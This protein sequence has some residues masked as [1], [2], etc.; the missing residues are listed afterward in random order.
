MPT[1]FSMVSVSVCVLG[2]IG[3]NYARYVCYGVG[4]CVH[5]SC[6]IGLGNI[7]CNYAHYV[8]DGVGQCVYM[9]IPG[10]NYAHYVYYGVGQCVYASCIAQ[11]K[12]KWFSFP[13]HFSSF[14]TV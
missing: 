7:S 13:S 9:G 14:F 12:K 2:N 1:M 5:V 11:P 3:C 8:Y 4:Q 6:I 10:C